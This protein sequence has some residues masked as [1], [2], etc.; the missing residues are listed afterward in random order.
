MQH[1]RLL[2]LLILVWQ[3]AQVAFALQADFNCLGVTQISKTE[4]QSLVSLYN[5]TGGDNWINRDGWLQNDTPCSWYGLACDNEG[6]L[7]R[8]ILEGNQLS[9]ELPPEL[10]NL[11]QLTWLQLNANQLSGSI[12]PA[13]GN[14]IHLI[15]LRL[16]NNQFSGSIPPELG[17]ISDLENLYLAGNSL[18]GTIPLELGN[19][20]QLQKLYLD[21]TGLSG[22]IPPELGNLTAL[23]TL[24]L[25]QNNNLGGPLPT[26]F[27]NLTSLTYFHYLDTTIC[28]PADEVFQAWLLQIEDHY[29]LEQVCDENVE[30][31]AA[32]PTSTTSPESSLVQIILFTFI[33]VLVVGG[34]VGYGWWLTK[35][36]DSN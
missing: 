6:H 31:N 17:H 11:S 21:A 15:W 4:C 1:A 12:P 9:G 7:S 29:G 13:L 20:T 8:I 26:T 5:E 3:N 22:T 23:T 36:A 16:E 30:Q 35:K 10:G 18:E 25:S 34:G 2:I 19:L 33:I 24:T 14:L 27:T 28:E 32:E